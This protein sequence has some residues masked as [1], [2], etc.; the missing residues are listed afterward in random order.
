[1]C[2]WRR[3]SFFVCECVRYVSGLWKDL[4]LSH[5]LVSAGWI[6]PLSYSC[7]VRDDSGS[8]YIA[9]VCGGEVTFEG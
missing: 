3:S 2:G 8:G 1:M 5:P 7:F 6:F 9:S 4:A